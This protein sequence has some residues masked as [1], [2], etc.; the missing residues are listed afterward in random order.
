M[1]T[2]QIGPS[3]FASDQVI[4]LRRTWKHVGAVRTG[5]ADANGV[6]TGDRQDRVQQS[7]TISVKL[8]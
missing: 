4:Q 1:T 8:R 7:G 5:L 6:M 3:W 2:W